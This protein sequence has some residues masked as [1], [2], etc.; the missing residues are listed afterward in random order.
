MEYIDDDD[1]DDG[2]IVGEVIVERGRGV[3]KPKTLSSAIKCQQQA[4]K[5]PFR[6]QPSCTQHHAFVCVCVCATPP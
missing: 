3:M 1:D 6:Q 2:V 4:T 5:R